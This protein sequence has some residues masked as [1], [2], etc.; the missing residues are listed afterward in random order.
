MAAS[1]RTY[2]DK[3]PVL[4][5]SRDGLLAPQVSQDV[6]PWE[7][8]AAAGIKKLRKARV[9]ELQLTAEARQSI[10]LS[11][12]QRILAPLRPLVRIPRYCIFVDHLDHSIE[13]VEAMLQMRVQA[14]KEGSTA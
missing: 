11:P 1:I 5:M 2:F 6:I 10:R 7:G 4:E 14:A 8:I 9:V 3:R 12:V 13:Q